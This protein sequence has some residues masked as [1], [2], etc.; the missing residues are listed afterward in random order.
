MATVTK[1]IARGIFLHKKQMPVNNRRDDA[2]LIY[3]F[4]VG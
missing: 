2:E 1:E 4:K 3:I